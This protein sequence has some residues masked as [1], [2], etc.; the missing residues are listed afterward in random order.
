MPLL[1]VALN[2][3]KVLAASC[4]INWPVLALRFLSLT[5]LTVELVFMI[6]H[7]LKMLESHVHVSS[8]N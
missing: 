1:S 2:M 7:I 8:S 3:D 4:S 5:V 6:V